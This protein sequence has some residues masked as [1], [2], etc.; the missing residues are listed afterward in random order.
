M[1]YKKITTLVLLIVICKTTAF[2]QQNNFYNALTAIMH[3]ATN[4]F[5]NIKGKTVSNSMYAIVWDCGIKIPGTIASRFVYANGTFY[6]GA[7]L[8]TNNIAD[9]KPV[10]EHYVTLLDSCLAPMGYE[11][12]LSENFYPDMGAYKKVAFLPTNVPGEKIENGVPHLAI[13]VTHS[14]E[15]EQYTVVLFIYEH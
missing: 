8:Q 15:K 12:I 6:E 13:E 3:D 2:A 4:Q 14:K 7:L 10:Y 5:R 1:L 9:V 11:K